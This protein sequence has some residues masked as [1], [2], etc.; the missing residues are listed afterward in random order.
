MQVFRKFKMF[1]SDDPF[2][3]FKYFYT[4]DL[5]NKIFYVQA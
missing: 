1:R 4:A 5:Q 3:S 2:L